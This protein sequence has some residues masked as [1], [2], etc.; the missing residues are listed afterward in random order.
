[1][2]IK[3]LEL[4]YLFE[5]LYMIFL[6]IIHRRY[7]L[8]FISLINGQQKVYGLITMEHLFSLTI[9]QLDKHR[10]MW[11]QIV[12]VLQLITFKLYQKFFMLIVLIQMK[13]YLNQIS[14]KILQLYLN[15]YK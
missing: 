14:N 9:K 15:F 10:Q 5:R 12:V 11:I 1:M 2:D 8:L 3:N 6:L 4:M 7:Q 13:S